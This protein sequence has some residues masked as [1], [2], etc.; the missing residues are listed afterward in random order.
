MKDF[1]KQK[2]LIPLLGINIIRTAL[3]KLHAFKHI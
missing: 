2:I 1:D 3:C